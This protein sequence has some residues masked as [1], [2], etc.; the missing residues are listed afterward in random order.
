MSVARVRKNH[1]R[2][3]AFL[4][5]WGGLALTSSQMAEVEKLGAQDVERGAEAGELLGFNGSSGTGHFTNTLVLFKLQEKTCPPHVAE[6]PTRTPMSVPPKPADAEGTKKAFAVGLS[7]I[8][9]V[10]PKGVRPY[11]W[12]LIGKTGRVE[13]ARLSVGSG[14]P[15]IDSL[16]VALAREIRFQPATLQD[17]PTCVWLRFRAPFPVSR[18]DRMQPEWSHADNED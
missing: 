5:F 13:D 6:N 16:A 2:T 1:R 17:Q 8:P 7:G 4:T 11:L 18:Q 12:V 14:F 3:V 15:G 9:D 10:V